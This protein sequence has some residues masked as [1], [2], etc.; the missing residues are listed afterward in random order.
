MAIPPVEREL[1]TYI[2]NRRILLERA[3]QAFFVLGGEGRLQ[4]RAL[5]RLD[6][7]EEGARIRFRD[8][9]E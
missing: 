3:A 4:Q 9:D 5:E 7:A 2:P 6:R 1:R 8:D